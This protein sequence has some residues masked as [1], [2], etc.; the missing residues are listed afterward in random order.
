MEKSFEYENIV[1][2]YESCEVFMN[3]TCLW[4]SKDLWKKGLKIIL[5]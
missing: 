5:I 1:G 4:K 2:D 3:E